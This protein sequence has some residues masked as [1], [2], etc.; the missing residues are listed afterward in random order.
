MTSAQTIGNVIVETPQGLVDVGEYC[1]EGELEWSMD[2][3][4]QVTFKII[5]RDLKMLSKG[6]FAL[7]QLVYFA[8][9]AWEI[10]GVEIGS[11]NGIEAVT[12][13]CRSHN[14]QRLK[15]EKGNALF[16]GGN[17]SS[18]AASKARQYGMRPFVENS[19]P[20]ENI[21]QS[22]NPF[23]EESVWDVLRKN[24]GED[25]YVLFET[26]NTLFYC[27]EQFLLGKFAVVDYSMFG[28]GQFLFT[29]IKWRPNPAWA[30]Q[31]QK[32]ASPQG[33]PAVSLG[34]KNNAWVAYA[35]R[36]LIER[37]G[38]L[39]YDPPGDY[40][41]STRQAVADIQSFFRTGGD[42]NV[43][44]WRTWGVIDFFANF[45]ELFPDRYAMTS[46][47]IPNARKSEDAK[48]SATLDLELPYTEGFYLR[49]GMTLRL[50]EVPEF[51]WYYL[52]RSV[53]VRLGTN[54]P[55]RISASTPNLPRN[56]LLKALDRLG[57]ISASGGGFATVAG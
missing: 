38:K 57:R 37:A 27:S 22:S 45:Y 36:V 52:V 31:Y 15:Y 6:F 30:P 32:I 19:P 43:I 3:V 34:A 46:I 39:I 17:A 21:T 49:P 8:I 7:R 13:Q 44:D 26:N 28:P 16:T 41:L 23:F 11:Q 29:P 51:T 10:S 18:Y 1:A 14:A 48:W 47:D 54:E 56:D 25:D 9:S 42:W 55:V 53:N 4:S 20:K 5:D 2:S 35:Q 50:D 33:R 12:I 40:G 24:A